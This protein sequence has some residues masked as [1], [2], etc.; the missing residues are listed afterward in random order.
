MTDPE[1]LRQDHDAQVRARAEAFG[2]QAWSAWIGGFGVL[3]CSLIAWAVFTR[4]AGCADRAETSFTIGGQTLRSDG[5]CTQPTN[6]LG[7][8]TTEVPGVEWLIAILLG[9]VSYA[10]VV[11]GCLAWIRMTT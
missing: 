10:L 2:L 4:P 6:L 8:P 11:Y 9:A 3:V 1:A 7:L 5:V